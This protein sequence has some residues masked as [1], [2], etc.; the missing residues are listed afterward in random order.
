MSEAVRAAVHSPREAEIAQDLLDS[1]HTIV[2]V[3]PAYN[4][5]RFIG[6]VV[7]NTLHYAH[8]VIVVDDG[9]TDRTTLLARLAGACVV[10]MPH[11]GGKGMALNAGFR[12]ARKFDP[13]VVVMLDG[14]AQ[15]E[16]SEIP[17]L[18]A[19]I[20]AGRADVVI[21]SRFMGVHSEIPRWRQMGQHTLTMVTNRASGTAISD[22]QSGFRAFN[23]EALEK[24][25]FRTAGLSVESE[26]QFQL[27][28]TNLRTA[29]VPISVQYL[30]G[31]KRNPVVHGVEVLNAIFTLVA[32]RRPLTMLGAPGI[33]IC[34][35][36]VVFGLFVVQTVDTRHVV[37][38]GT[39][40]LSTLF[41]LVGVLLTVTAVILQ[42]I[43]LAMDRMIQEV[44]E[45]VEMRDGA[46]NND[47]R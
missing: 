6:S 34:A 13:A 1:H 43:N 31:N 42:S 27:D 9:S 14:D 5:E 47:G 20:L 25:H 18:A 29:E 12:E 16:P 2:A 44:H 21:G 30:D 36:G 17:V 19:P 33:T 45:L 38:I 8:H 10:E 7:L 15:H 24:L 46:A 39:A 41:I 22:S 4:E 32:K 40:V 28:A 37:P 11:N 35:L 26:M 23:V 3:I